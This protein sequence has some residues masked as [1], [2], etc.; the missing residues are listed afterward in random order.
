MKTSKED[1]LRL[2]FNPYLK[3]DEKFKFVAYGVKQPNFFVL[4]LL[5]ISI[6]GVF[7]LPSLTKHFIIGLTDKR[8]IILQINGINNHK[9][10][11]IIEYPL[12]ELPNIQIITST[13]LL[14][15]YFDIQYDNESFKAKCHRGYSK[16]NRENAIKIAEAISK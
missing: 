3:Q 6:I 14:F 1:K 10:K 12:V 16:T 13:R 9:V 2:A 4:S 15:T 11:R 7:I 8:L 5:I